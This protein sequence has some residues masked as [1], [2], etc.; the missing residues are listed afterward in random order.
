MYFVTFKSLVLLCLLF[1]SIVYVLLHLTVNN[2]V[3]FTNYHAYINKRNKCYGFF[4]KCKKCFDFEKMSTLL[5]NSVHFRSSTTL[6]S[7]APTEAST[8]DVEDHINVVTR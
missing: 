7:T 4:F 3:Q 6:S 5:Y 2:I 1:V 8:D